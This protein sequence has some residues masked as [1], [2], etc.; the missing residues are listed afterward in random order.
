M[1]P[2]VATSLPIDGAAGVAITV[3]PYAIYDQALNPAS[4]NAMTVMLLTATTLVPIA[5]LPSYDST[6]KKVI[7]TPTAPLSYSSSYIF[8]LVGYQVDVDTFEHGIMNNYGEAQSGIVDITFTTMDTPVVPDP[9]PPTTINTQDVLSVDPAN[10]TI[11]VPVDLPAHDHLI[12]LEFNYP[13]PLTQY[14]P[15][16]TGNSTKWSTPVIV[17][18]K[19]TNS[20]AGVLN[21]E[22]LLDVGTGEYTFNLKR[23]TTL[24]ATGT[25]TTDGILYF[26]PSGTTGIYGSIIVT[27]AA[28]AG[29]G[30]MTVTYGKVPLYGNI[31]INGQNCI[32]LYGAAYPEIEFEF[33]WPSLMAPPIAA[34]GDDV[35]IGRVSYG[36][37][38]YHTVTIEVGHYIEDALNNIVWEQLDLILSYQYVVS[39]ATG[40]GSTD[41]DIYGLPVD[42]IYYFV[43]KIEPMYTTITTIL[44]NI[45]AYIRGVPE[46]TIARMIYEISWLVRKLYYELHGVWLPVD[47]IDDVP[48]EIIQYVICK[49]KLDTLDAALADYNGMGSGVGKTLG[50]F[51][52][53]RA[54][55]AGAPFKYL[56]DKYLQCI[57]DTSHELGFSDVLVARTT[58]V[59]EFDPRR[60]ISE[61]SWRRWPQVPTTMNQNG[62]FPELS[63]NIVR[64]V[65]PDV[66]LY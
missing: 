38:L 54:A 16:I 22:L 11:M 24:V 40:V 42:H 52:V 34:T 39:I 43:T 51:K 65:P 63:N 5:G 14:I 19:S 61:Y 4:V 25:A 18:V 15:T 35:Y 64:N 62:M 56:R 21:W 36:D 29:T 13:V 12:T 2:V 59:A 41:D 58:V 33:E 28:T 31:T 57:A 46:D 30:T 10:A 55:V 1:R 7:F 32:G 53:D 60:P 47:D 48:A 6:Y 9:D 37:A 23:G 27:T 8:R 26:E 17:G 50:D 20:T 3:A 66:G 45:G 44:L 49:V